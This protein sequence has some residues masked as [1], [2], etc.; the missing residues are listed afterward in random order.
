MAM[1]ICA[2]GDVHAHTEFEL[3][4]ELRAGQFAI[5]PCVKVRA[6]RIFTR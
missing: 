3:V 6:L 1:Q 5:F 4:G 2:T